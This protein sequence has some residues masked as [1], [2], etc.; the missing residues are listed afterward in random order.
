MSID[1]IALTRELVDL[2]S[3]TYHEGALGL[4][5]AELLKAAG[6]AV[7]TMPV[8]QPDHLKT[9]GRGEGERFNVYA[10]MPGVKPSVVLSTHMDTV[11]PV[12]PLERRRTVPLW[13]RHLR[14]E[15]HYC[16]TDCGG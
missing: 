6:F 2:E 4:Y 3:T 1:P 12:F 15:G 8:S 10:T 14:C 16:R 7:E 13:T 11:P 5:L 9:P